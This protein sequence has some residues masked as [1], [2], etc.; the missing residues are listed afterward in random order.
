[1]ACSIFL[2]GFSTWYL[3]QCGEDTLFVGYLV[4]SACLWKGKNRI[5][6]IVEKR[7]CVLVSHRRNRMCRSGKSSHLRCI[8]ATKIQLRGIRREVYR[9]RRACRKRRHAHGIVWVLDVS[10]RPRPTTYI[11]IGSQSSPL[12]CVSNA[13]FWAITTEVIPRFLH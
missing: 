3:C 12:D 2:L 6:L 5:S 10:K 8:E 13:L 7:S 9:M 1:M 11:R 4:G